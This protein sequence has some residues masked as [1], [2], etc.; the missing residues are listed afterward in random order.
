MLNKIHKLKTMS[1]EE[2]LFRVK[3]QLYL[4]TDRMRHKILGSGLDDRSFLRRV[5]TSQTSATPSSR[6][7]TIAEPS[8]LTSA[9]STP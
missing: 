9:E 6:F 7:A 2:I 5:S 1:A 8:G 4:R 3:A